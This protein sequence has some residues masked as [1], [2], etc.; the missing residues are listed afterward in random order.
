LPMAFGKSMAG[1][2]ES[3]SFAAAKTTMEHSR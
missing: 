2:A 3:S 1:K